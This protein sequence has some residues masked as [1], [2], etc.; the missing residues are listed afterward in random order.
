MLQDDGWVLS[1]ES[2]QSVQSWNT[3]TSLGLATLWKQI[4][5]LILTLVASNDGIASNF[6]LLAA[7]TV[8]G[9][10][11]GKQELPV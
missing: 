4:L 1:A 3:W 9:Y 2:L 7:W 11:Y 6:K 10:Y 8:I 5:Q